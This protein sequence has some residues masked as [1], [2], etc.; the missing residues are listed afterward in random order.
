MVMAEG[1]ETGALAAEA[2]AR[3]LDPQ[4]VAVAARIGRARRAHGPARPGDGGDQAPHRRGKDVTA[5][6]V[7]CSGCGAR[8]GTF[9]LILGRWIC[10][11]H[12]PQ[13]VVAIRRAHRDL[14]AS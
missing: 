12:V 7:V 14:L 2:L 1:R 5:D 4:W 3:G 10:L 6:A 11:S 9:V 13:R 8:V